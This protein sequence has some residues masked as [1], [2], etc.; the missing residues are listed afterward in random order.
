[1]LGSA[2]DKNRDGT[3][4]ECTPVTGSIAAYHGCRVARFSYREQVATTASADDCVRAMRDTLTDLGAGPH[5]EGTAVVGQLGSRVRA[6][7]FGSAFVLQD[8]E[9]H[10]RRDVPPWLPVRISAQVIDQGTERLLV[11]DVAENFGFGSLT[12][13]DGDYRLRCEQVLSEV[14]HNARL[15]LSAREASPTTTPPEPT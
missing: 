8:G 10:R 1:M 13:A 3:V 2:G 4:T 5:L 11:I 15:R 14:T 7:L 6:R 9:L 12:G